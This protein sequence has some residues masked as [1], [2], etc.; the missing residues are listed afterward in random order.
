MSNMRVQGIE[1]Y[2]PDKLVTNDYFIKKFREEHGKEIEHLLISMGRNERYFA[3]DNPRDTSLVMGYKA[4]KKVMESCNLTGN[5]IDLLIFSS[6]SPEYICPPMSVILCGWLGT[7]RDVQMF[8]QNVNGLGMVSATITIKNMMDGNPNIKRALLV[9]SENFTSICTEDNEYTYPIIADMACAVVYER[10]DD[11]VSGFIGHG[12]SLCD[13]M[14]ALDNVRYPKNGMKKSF[15]DSAYDRKSYLGTG[16]DVSPIPGA[17]KELF[18]KYCQT[19]NVDFKKIKHF[20][21][22]QFN[23]KMLCGIVKELEIDFD[24]CIYIGDKYGY[25]GTSSPF[26]ALWYGINTGKIKRGDLIGLWSLGLWWTTA[27]I[28]FRY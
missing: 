20:C 7:K 27:L 9:G 8:D 21:M 17:T 10:T 25:T 11:P 12:S 15:E 3:Y 22:S 5:D 14:K 2:H 16:L 1:I 4:A 13:C 6:Q 23:Y 24:K 26:V 18:N 28:L 19:Y